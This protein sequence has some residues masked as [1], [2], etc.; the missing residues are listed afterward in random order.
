MPSLE[1]E[2]KKR[3]DEFHFKIMA[4]GNLESKRRR[5]KGDVVV[6]F[7]DCI[8]SNCDY[9]FPKYPTREH[10]KIA[11]IIDN[12]ISELEDFMKIEKETKNRKYRKISN[13]EG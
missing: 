6:S 2:R 12:K 11:S 1:F 5:R 4:D 7:I 13:D 8:F 10:W 3:T 9:A